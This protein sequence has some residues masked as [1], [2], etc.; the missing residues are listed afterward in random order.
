MVLGQA[1]S[2]VTTIVLTCSSV[3]LGY[4]Q[5][6]TE[7]RARTGAEE[8]IREVVLR[9]QILSWGGDAD[10]VEKNAATANDKAI[11]GRLNPRVYFISVNGKDPTDEFLK[12]LQDIP[13]N[14]KKAS[15]AKQT[16]RFP[17][18]VVDKKTKAPGIVFSANEIRWRSD[19][20]VEVEG[21]Y[22]CGGL[23]AAGDV[24]AVG[25]ADGKW[26][27]LSVRMKWIS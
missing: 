14:L 7:P 2:L 10:K 16:K 11:A 23:C 24:F 21:G 19:D 18:W 15:Q 1:K 4:A 6:V 25:F 20:E 8:D 27:V 13:R 5:S 26:K 22:H 12:R 3:V 17:G 9:Y